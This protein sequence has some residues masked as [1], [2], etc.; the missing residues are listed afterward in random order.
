MKKNNKKFKGM[1]LIE[2]IISLAVFAMIGVILITVAVTIQKQ[3]KGAQGLNKKVAVQGP[4]AEAQ[5]KTASAVTTQPVEIE[6]RYNA[7]SVN[8]QGVLYDTAVRVQATD[9]AG[10]PVT[11][12]A[13]NPVFEVN[14][15]M[16]GEINLKYV[17]DI[18]KPT[19][20]PTT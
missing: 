3:A 9:A 11:D 7:S 17:A 10:D 6:V 12:G 14:G 2:I 5:N 8:V 19:A 18:Q 1:T 20:A 16:N 13:G 15:E 4:I